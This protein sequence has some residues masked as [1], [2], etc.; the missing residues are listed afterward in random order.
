VRS[1]VAG[2]ALEMLTV[3]QDLWVEVEGLRECDRG[4]PCEDGHITL[5]WLSQ[6]IRI[7]EC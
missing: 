3:G 2:L 5:G 4:A 7:C 1:L 6:G